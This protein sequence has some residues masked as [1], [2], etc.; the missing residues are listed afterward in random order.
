M[1]EIKEINREKTVYQWRCSPEEKR[2]LL[3]QAAEEKRTANKVLSEALKLYLRD[4][5]S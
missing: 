4:K 2:L 1:I 5:L 3:T